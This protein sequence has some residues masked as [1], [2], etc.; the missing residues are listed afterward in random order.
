[1]N[2]SRRISDDYEVWNWNSR[3]RKG[4]AKGYYDSI[5]TLEVKTAMMGMCRSQFFIDDSGRHGL[6]PIGTRVGDKIALLVGGRVPYILRR[7]PRISDTQ[8]HLYTFVGECYLHVLWTARL[9][10]RTSYMISL[11]NEVEAMSSPKLRNTNTTS[12]PGS[13]RSQ[14]DSDFNI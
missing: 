6:G 10:T 7:S 5:R 11:W 12:T 4:L 9:S 1:M 13:I 14:G 2:D 3:V 8:P